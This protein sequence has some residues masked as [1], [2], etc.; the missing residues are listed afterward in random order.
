MQKQ[1]VLA[2]IEAVREYCEREFTAELKPTIVGGELKNGVLTV[3][4]SAATLVQELEAFHRP[5]LLT[6]VRT[7]APQVARIR[8]C[9]A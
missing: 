6:V 4:C 3:H 1:A 5:A 7:A 8:I 9:A 2:A